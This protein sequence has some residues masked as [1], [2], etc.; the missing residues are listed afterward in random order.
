MPGIDTS[1]PFQSL[2]I[3]ILTISDTR[4]LSEDRS[5]DLLVKRLTADGHN[6]AVRDLVRDDADVIASKLQEWIGDASIDII[7]TTG[8]TGLTGRDITPEAFARVIEK[9]IPGF[10][11]LFRMLSYESIGTS[12]VQ[13]RALAG[14]A[15]GTYLFGLPGSTGAC[16]DGWDKI[17]HFQ[18]D[19][20]HKPCNFA[21]LIPRLREHE[22]D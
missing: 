3:A 20:R 10:G 1:L 18:L 21:E 12:T 5:G 9:D 19:I 22:T 11:E 2:R 15:R 6:L 13:S 14:V 17:L 4:S 7:I 16:K 8:G